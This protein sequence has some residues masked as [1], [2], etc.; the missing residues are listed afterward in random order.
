MR[1][2]VSP[3][4]L[5]FDAR[6]KSLK[7]ASFDAERATSSDADKR[8]SAA[9]RD[10]IFQAAIFQSSAA[11]ED[12]LKT[13]FDAWAFK[14]KN[15]AGNCIAI[16]PRVRASI[17]IE[18]LSAQFYNYA[19]NRNEIELIKKL[20]SKVSLWELLEG[21]K[22]IP[23]HFDGAHLY[24]NRKYP[25]PKNLKILFHRI[26]VENI[27]D[28]ASKI[29]RSDAE[30]KLVAFNAIR[31]ALA[32]AEPPQITYDDVRRNVKDVQSLIRAF[33]RVI[34]QRFIAY[35]GQPLW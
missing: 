28:D 25:S 26:G 13:V 22:S 29:I 1:Y 16:P 35:L 2:K 17:A 19:A 14:T 12:Y 32:H 9:L 18:E 7:A 24:K 10:L 15:N 33:D 3:Y 34:H 8:I 11:M 6:T 20:E 31:T 30:M 21:S 5:A 27:F 4:R 23:L